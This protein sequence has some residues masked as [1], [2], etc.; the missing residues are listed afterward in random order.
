M[1]GFNKNKLFTVYTNNG[2]IGLLICYKVKSL[3]E[4]LERAGKELKIVWDEDG[5]VV[6][7][8]NEIE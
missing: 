7:N 8:S 4:I 5:D 6:Y 2:L 1:L 3:T